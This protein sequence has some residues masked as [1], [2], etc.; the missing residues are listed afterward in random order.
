MTSRQS[1]AEI[2]IPSHQSLRADA[3]S[4]SFDC[5]EHKYSDSGPSEKKFEL[6]RGELCTIGWSI[7]AVAIAALGTLAWVLGPYVAEFAMADASVS[8]G[9][10]V[11]ANHS[12]LVASEITMQDPTPLRCSVGP[13]D[14]WV[15]DKEQALGK[16]PMPATSKEQSTKSSHSVGTRVIDIADDGRWK[17]ISSTLKEKEPLTWRLTGHA[18]VTMSIIGMQFKFDGVPFDKEIPL[19]KTT[20]SS[21]IN[22]AHDE[23]LD[24]VASCEMTKRRRGRSQGLGYGLGRTMAKAMVKFVSAPFQ[25]RP[26]SLQQIPAASTHI[27]SH[28]RHPPVYI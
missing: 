7:V 27:G 25:P 16:L 23:V 24:A 13:M 5:E 20:R 28:P 11:L 17:A 8:F 4:L 26:L 1:T 6:S 22:G 3:L 9:T 2:S 14:L 21:G 19:R 12:I 18:P 10:C 15:M